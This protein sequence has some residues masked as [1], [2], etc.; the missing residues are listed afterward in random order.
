[1]CETKTE[2]MVYVHKWDGVQNDRGEIATAPFNYIGME[3]KGKVAGSCNVCCTGIRYFF[4]IEGANGVQFK[5]GGDCVHKSGD[6]KLITVV[7]KAQKDFDKKRK[8]EKRKAAWAAA[9]ERREAALAAERVANGGLTNAEKAEAVKKA[10]AD[11]RR[12]VYTHENYWLLNVL[13]R[14]N[15]GDFVQS[16]IERLET[17]PVAGLSPRMLSVLKDIYAKSFG[18]GGSEAYNAAADFFVDKV[19]P[20]TP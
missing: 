8:E 4:Y 7:E 18:R 13:D 19:E 16:M 12:A 2:Q 14:Q 3:D 11:Q 20:I 15:G 9:C 17:G 1:M 5:V 6:A 10:E